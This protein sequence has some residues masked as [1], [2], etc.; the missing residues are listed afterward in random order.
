MNKITGEKR[1]GEIHIAGE[2]QQ[3]KMSWGGKINDLDKVTKLFSHSFH[4]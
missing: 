3:G 2:L 4:D 1:S